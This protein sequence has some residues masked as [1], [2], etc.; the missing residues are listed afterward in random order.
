[1]SFPPRC[2]FDGPTVLSKVE[3]EY[4]V[5]LQF[6]KE[7]QQLITNVDRRCR[8]IISR[9]PDHIA[10]TKG[11]A[12]NC[13]RIHLSVYP[14]EAVSLAMA[15]LQMAPGIQDRIQHKALHTNSF[16]PCPLLEDGACLMYDARAV[17]CRTHGLPMLTEY[18]GHRS[19]GFC[20]KNFKHRCPVPEE[21]IIDLSQIHRSLA[22]VNRRFIQAAGHHLP[23]GDRFTI[24]QALVPDFFKLRRPEETKG[25]SAI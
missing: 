13:C 23:S 3:G 16:G 22:E 24:A 19:I 1:M 25:T 15:L 2:W 14:V 18:R 11:C 8:R 10:C 4:G 21:D 7:Y 6:L 20:S 5:I 9:H 12:G 17:I